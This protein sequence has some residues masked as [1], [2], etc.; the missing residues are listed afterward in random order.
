MG[1]LLMADF[2]KAMEEELSKRN[3]NDANSESIKKIKQMAF[4]ETIKL[5]NPSISDI[6]DAIDK[7]INK[8]LNNEKAA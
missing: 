2:N 6:Q 8:V 7:S 1:Q 5:P 3:L 4:R